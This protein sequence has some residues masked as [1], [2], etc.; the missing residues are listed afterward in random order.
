MS[1]HALLHKTSLLTL[2]FIKTLV[3]SSKFKEGKESSTPSLFQKNF[4]G[5]VEFA[6]LQVG[7]FAVI[8]ENYG[9]ILD[10]N[11]NGDIKNFA[12]KRIE[13]TISQQP[14]IE[15]EVALSIDDEKQIKSDFSGAEIIQ[16][17]TDF[18]PEIQPSSAFLRIPI[19]SCF[20][21]DLAK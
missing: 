15:H 3:Q 19:E 21:C 18:L 10:L 17:S 7:F 4:V 11:N 12:F 1:L 16:L 6:F 8:L 5:L 2:F 20:C 13:K 9:K 14:R